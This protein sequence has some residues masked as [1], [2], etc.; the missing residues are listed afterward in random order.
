MKAVLSCMNGLLVDVVQSVV[1]SCL[2]TELFVSCI[3]I[4]SR[5]FPAA[6]P[7]LEFACTPHK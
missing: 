3:F 4:T 7:S 2:F 1:S 6:P 5:S